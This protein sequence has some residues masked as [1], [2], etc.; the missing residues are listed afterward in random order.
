MTGR[1][2][3]LRKP[4]C[5]VSGMTTKSL[6][7]LCV[8]LLLVAFQ[9]SCN[10]SNSQSADVTLITAAGKPPGATRVQLE[11][12]DQ[13]AALRFSSTQNTKAEITFHGLADTI[14]TVQL[15]Y[16]DASGTDVGTFSTS[17]D[18]G[19]PT[20]IVDPPTV[21]PSD[22][23]TTSVAY[24]G[25]NRVG[26]GA[27]S[28]N[29][30]ST[31]NVANL[32]QDFTEIPDPTQHVPVPSH[33]LFVGDLVVNH[34][35][36]TTTL[37]SQLEG[38]KA[39]Y[40]SSALSTSSVALVTIAG[41]HEMLAKVDVGGQSVEVSNPPTGTVF[42]SMMAAFIPAG[43]G[44]TEAP[45]NPD[46]VA[47]D[48]SQ[49]SFSFRDGNRMFVLLD[50]D[51]YIGDD[52]PDGI[53]YVPLNWLQ[54]QLRQAQSDA[55]IG[56][57]FVFGHKPIVGQEGEGETIAPSQRAAFQSVLCDPSGR[58][59]PTKVRGY[60]CAHAHYWDYDSLPCPSAPGML[61]QVIN[62]NGGTSVENAF[63][64]PPHGFFGYTILGVT[65]SGRVVL[66]AWGRP[67]TVP[68]DAP[69]QAPATLREHRTLAG[70]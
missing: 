69:N 62:G 13:F 65:R 9:W 30:P 52:S 20:T 50:T 70:S 35:T 48:E 10:G 34:V 42:T 33:V 39:V 3:Q 54:E 7:R 21:D 28:E 38:W 6:T 1:V 64:E 25:C 5:I 40:E 59:E 29:L 45:P 56:H 12:F 23:V 24:L 16:F 60:F 43:N 55:T 31:A 26:D 36:G 67:V 27:A 46:G 61:N 41:N 47:R 14:V 68:D 53:G 57:V 8:G 58:G 49:L 2:W 4:P 32:L 63:F 19:T 44:P 17:I 51:T 11:G 18:V 22:P 15:D 66:E 37:E